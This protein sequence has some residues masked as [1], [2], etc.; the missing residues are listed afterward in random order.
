MEATRGCRKQ[1]PSKLCVSILWS[2]E[3]GKWGVDQLDTEKVLVTHTFVGMVIG[4]PNSIQLP[5]IRVSTYLHIVQHTALRIASSDECGNY[6]LFNEFWSNMTLWSQQN[7][8]KTR[9]GRKPRP[10]Q[11]PHPD[12]GT[13]TWGIWLGKGNN[14]QWHGNVVQYASVCCILPQIRIRRPIQISTVR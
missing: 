13:R 1:R 7:V 4:T 2:P 8:Y 9:L 14:D 10:D 5:L 3:K 6:P 12:F 11:W